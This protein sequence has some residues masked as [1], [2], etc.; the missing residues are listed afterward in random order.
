MS[1]T[2]AFKRLNVEGQEF[3]ASLGVEEI[4]SFKTVLFVIA[5]Q[6]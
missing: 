6:I 1:T 5:F 2:S 4:I 3:K